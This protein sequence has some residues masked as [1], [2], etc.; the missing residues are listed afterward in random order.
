MGDELGKASQRTGVT[1]EAL[2]ALKYAADQSGTSLEDVEA[3]L[4]KMNKGLYEAASGSQAGQKVADA[5][6]DIG[7]SLS[8]LDGLSPDEKLIKIGGAL[9]EV[10]D[11]SAKTALAM[12]IL[13]KSSVGLFPLF[14]E[15]AEGVHNLKER[16]KELGL[17][18]ST[19]DSK[20]AI[21]FG[22]ILGDLW[23]QVGRVTFEGG[24]AIAEFL[25]PF[26]D[27]ATKVMRTVIDWTKAHNPLILQVL[28]L[29]AALTVAGSALISI[30]LS[31]KV[32]GLAVAGLKIGLTT[33]YALVSA[34]ISPL[35]LIAIAVAGIAAYFLF[36]TDT[37]SQALGS[38][39]KTLGE[40][41]TTA[42]DTFSAI[43]NALAS[44]EISLA[45]KILWTGLKLAWDQGT[46]DLRNLWDSFITNSAR[47][48]VIG[49]Y[50]IISAFEEVKNAIKVRLLEIQV[51]FKNTWSA[52]VDSVTD[53]IEAIDRENMKSAIDS[54]VSAGQTSP[55][56]G[57]KLKK[58]IDDEYDAAKKARNELS[59]DERTANEQD[60]QA[61]LA[62]IEATKKARLDALDAEE[63]AVLNSLKKQHESNAGALQKEIED[64]KKQLADLKHGSG[65]DGP[66][67]GPFL[68]D[69]KPQNKTKIMQPKEFAQS[70]S[71]GTFSAG[72]VAGLGPDVMER[73][74]KATERTADNTDQEDTMGE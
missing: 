48:A 49:F 42:M 60:K 13:G 44:G 28:A 23:K 2:G 4:K 38:I 16:F 22:D 12:I 24:K 71:T 19:K 11:Q 67:Y 20:T 36:F 29:G 35:G 58:Y 21:V 63:K 14:A 64:L 72:A 3:S 8:D 65:P 6:G 74:A 73:I 32:A 9:N 33:V 43:A 53:A 15:G 56:E 54:Q 40:L 30:G 51:L 25:L 50:G 41:K 47:G 37:G 68:S 69:G 18:I 59:E 17:E 55:E 46:Q 52:A 61:K 1:V 57:E 62:A 31:F 5:L 10:Q 26:A 45:A 27:S 39:T 7:L 34:L 70:F 66:L